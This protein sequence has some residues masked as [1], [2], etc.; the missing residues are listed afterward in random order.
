MGRIAKQLKQ[1][2]QA[3]IPYETNVNL[4]QPYRQGIKLG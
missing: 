3:E 2:I 1:K 4:E